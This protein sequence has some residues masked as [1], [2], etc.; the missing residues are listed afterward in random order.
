MKRR[1]TTM[2]TAGV[3]RCCLYAI[4]E[5]DLD[6]DVMV[7]DTFACPYC[8]TTFTLTDKGESR[9]VY[10]PD[11]QIVGPHIHDQRA[12]AKRAVGAAK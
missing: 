3:I 7:G 9:L 4:G 11:W 6:A 10:I 12:G 8:H 1:D 2:T 5:T